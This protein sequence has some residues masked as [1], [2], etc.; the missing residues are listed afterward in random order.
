MFYCQPDLIWGQLNIGRTLL[1]NFILSF[2]IQA[3]ETDVERGIILHR[4]D[5]F[6]H[7][8]FS[9]YF[10]VMFLLPPGHLQRKETKLV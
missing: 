1:I 2:R 10:C 4:I 9:P 7:K 5:A 3:I 8:Y 6:K